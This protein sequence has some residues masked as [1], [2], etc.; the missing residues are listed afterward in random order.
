[1]L[2]YNFIPGTYLEDP[3]PIKSQVTFNPEAEANNI[4]S[5]LR[6]MRGTASTLGIMPDPEFGAYQS[7]ELPEVNDRSEFTKGLLRGVDST[8][9]LL[10]GGIGAVGDVLGMDS[11]RDWGYENYARNMEEAEENKA[12]IGS[13]SEVNSL[14][15]FGQ[16]TMGVLGELAPTAAGALASGGI[17]AL[18]GKYYGSKLIRK[19]VADQIENQVQKGIAD[20]A[21]KGIA[22]EAVEST[23]RKQAQQQ[24]MGNLMRKG[25]TAAVGAYTS[26]TEGGG[27]W[28]Q[29]VAAHGIE[30]ASPGQDLLFG[31][32][33]GAIETILGAEISLFKSLTGKTVSD[34]VEQSFRK[35]LVKGFA[36]A[37]LS[38]GGQEAIQETLSSINANILDSKGLIT[39]EDIEGIFNAAVAGAI[40]GVAFHLPTSW[41]DARNRKKKTAAQAEID[42]I[43]KKIEEAKAQKAEQERLQTIE[44]E[45]IAK[46]Q[47]YQDVVNDPRT[48]FELQL[49]KEMDDLNAYWDQEGKDLYSAYERHRRALENPSQ[50]SP[51]AIKAAQAFMKKFVPFQEAR[52]ASII[53]LSREQE[54]KRSQFYSNRK[55]PN[56]EVEQIERPDWDVTQTYPYQAA[57]EMQ[58]Q[59][60]RLD[61]LA[62][63]FEQGAEEHN[64][65]AM[66]EEE[67]WRASRSATRAM[68]PARQ[69]FEQKLLNEQN[70][71]NS[72]WDERGKKIYSAYSAAKAVLERPNEFSAA[73][74]K[75]A[76]TALNEYK[77]FEQERSTAQTILSNRQQQERT[78]FYSGRTREN[79]TP[80]V[81][82]L[83]LDWDPSLSYTETFNFERAEEERKLNELGSMFEE[84]ARIHDLIA[85][86]DRAE[87]NRQ[88]EGFSQYTPGLVAREQEILNRT[89]ISD[90]QKE[91]LLRN[92]RSGRAYPDRT[93]APEDTRPTFG[94]IQYLRDK[95]EA[96]KLMPLLKAREA[97][98]IQ[99]QLWK[100]YADREEAAFKE[101]WD[102]KEASLLAQLQKFNQIATQ[103]RLTADQEYDRAQLYA[104]HA[105]FL[106]DKKKA[107][108]ALDAKIKAGYHSADGVFLSE[109]RIAA[110][111]VYQQE[112]IDRALGS[113][114]YDAISDALTEA[115]TYF[116][117]ATEAINQRI[118]D[119][120]TA[121]SEENAAL[122]QK[123]KDLT[124]T[125]DD[126][127]RHKTRIDNLTK[128]RGKALKS[129][130]KM[131]K[132]MGDISKKNAVLSSTDLNNLG[133]AIQELY[134]EGETILNLQR[135]EDIF[136]DKQQLMINEKKAK[137]GQLTDALKR[138]RKLVENNIDQES[139]ARVSQIF[140]NV[141]NALTNS[142]FERDYPLQN[143]EAKTTPPSVVAQREQQQEQSALEDA[144]IKEDFTNTFNQNLTSAIE[145]QQRA[146]EKEDQDAH[147]A[148]VQAATK[149]K[150]SSVPREQLARW[151]KEDAARW[152][153][154]TLLDPS[155]ANRPVL[156]EMARDTARVKAAERKAQEVLASAQAAMNMTLKEQENPATLASR[157]LGQNRKS[158]KEKKVHSV[159]TFLKNTLKS[160]PGLRDNTVICYDENDASI[161][162]ELK[163]MLANVNLGLTKGIKYLFTGDI[164]AYNIR[165][166]DEANSR[167]DNLAIAEEMER[168]GDDPRRIKLATGWERHRKDGKWRYELDDSIYRTIESFDLGDTTKT[169]TLSDILLGA[170]DLFNSYPV[171]M[172][173]TVE[174]KSLS[175]SERGSYNP[176]TNT[177][178]INSN[179]SSADKRL[180]LLHE[181]QHSIQEIE[182][183]TRGTST[184]AVISKRTLD[185]LRNKVQVKRAEKI[186]DEFSSIDSS[187]SIALEFLPMR[188]RM[189]LKHV[190]DPS[191]RALFKNNLSK[192]T[193]YSYLVKRLDAFI[194]ELQS[195]TVTDTDAEFQ[196]ERVIY[197]T[198]RILESIRELESKTKRAK[199][200][201]RLLS[202]VNRRV[203]PSLYKDAYEVY[204]ENAGEVEAR[205]VAHR[206]NMTYEERLNSLIEDTQ[207]VSYEDQQMLYR[208]MGGQVKGVYYKGKLYLFAKNLDSKE[209]AI[210]TLIHE[211]VAHYGLRSIMNDE[212]L[213]QFLNLVFNSFAGTESWK[214]FA[215]ARPEYFKTNDRLTQAEEYVAYIAEQM[216]VSELINPENQSIFNRIVMFLRNILSKLGLKTTLTHKDI[217]DVLKLSAYNLQ[218]KGGQKDLINELN[219]IDMYQAD[220]Q[221]KEMTLSEEP[222][223]GVKFD[224]VQN[225]RSYFA[226]ADSARTGI[227]YTRFA[228]N[229]PNL[230]NT[231]N[232]ND[233]LDEQHDKIKTR[234]AK[235]ARDF[236]AAPAIDAVDNETFYVSMFN[237][238][239]G[240]YPSEQDARTFIDNDAMLSSITG[241]D[242]YNFLASTMDSK[243][244]ATEIMNAYGIRGAQ[245]LNMGKN[246]YYLF[247]GNNINMVPYQYNLN[248]LSEPK[249]LVTNPKDMV[250]DP[251]T[252]EPT[253]KDTPDQWTYMNE[254][255][256]QVA[257][258]SSWLR[259]VADVIKTGTSRADDGTLIEHNGW[260]RFIEGTV[261]RYRRL[262]VVQDYLKK[263]FKGAV[264]FSTNVY[265]NLQGLTNRI[266]RRQV[267]ADNK[268]LKPIEDV[269][270]EVT[271]DLPIYKDGKLIGYKKSTDSDYQDFMLRLFDGFLHARH[272]QERNK[273]VSE[274]FR[275]RRWLDKDGNPH[276]KNMKSAEQGQD[277]INASGM[278]DAEAQHL[279]DTLGSISGFQEAAALV[280][281]MNRYTLE[282]MLEM[283]LI[284][285]ED[286]N[287]MAKYNYYVPL[288]GWED[289]VEHF[290]PG[291]YR[292]RGR[293]LSTGGKRPV[294][295][296]KGRDNKLPASP[297][298]RSWQQMD[299][300]I[301]LGMRNE[302][303]RGF[304][305]LVKN[306]SSETELWEVD[307]K[308]PEA[309]RLQ[310]TKNG[311]I[312]LVTKPSE[313]HGSG[314][315]AVS[316]IDE[317]GKPVRIVIK[318]K[319]LADAMRGENMAPTGA[320][321]DM[322]RKYTGM[323]SKLMTSRNPLFAMVNPIRDM[324]T[325]ALNLGSVIEENQ[326]RGLMEKNGIIQR[327]V[328]TDVFSK[329]KLN[330]LWDMASMDE[331]KS[332]F[333]A[334]KYDPRDVQDLMDWRKNGGHTKSISV[335]DMKD[336]SKALRAGIRKDGIKKHYD[337]AMS[338]LDMLSDMT[339]NVVRFSVYQNVQRAFEENIHRR[340]QAEGWSSAR[341][342]QEIEM[343][344]QKSAN[345]ALDCTVNFTKRGAWANV[346]NPLF[347]FS[348]ASIQGFARIANNLWRPTS[349]P[350]QNFKRVSKFMAM[351][352]CAPLMHGFI[353][354][355]IM[356][357]DE[358]GLNKYDKIPAYIKETNLIIPMPFGDGGYIKV[359]LPYGYNVFWSM[360][361]T[362]DTVMAGHQ[363]PAD[364]ALSIIK[365][366]LS[367]ITP[368][369]PSQGAVAF[370]PTIFKPL[371]ELAAN[372]N[373]AG[374]PI[375]PE[376]YSTDMLPEHMKS[377]ERTP[378]GY[379]DIAGLLNFITGGFMTKSN[380]GA[381]DISP[382]T[383]EHLAN[384]YLGGIYRIFSQAADLA[385]S[386]MMGY[387]VEA[388]NIP[389][390]NRLYGVTDD[391]N[392]RA[393]YNR[394]ADHVRSAQVLKKQLKGTEEE[395]DL[396]D[397][398]R[399][400]FSVEKQYTAVNTELNKVKQAKKDLAKRYPKRGEAYYNQLKLLEKREEKIMQKFNRVAHRAGLTME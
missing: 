244:K 198:E 278:S 274:R 30:S 136:R 29:D 347:A 313:L 51:R 312:I 400:V 154:I 226:D 111:N 203:S 52:N 291:R 225:A 314:D 333:D 126:W 156:E 9:A 326:M 108:E 363:H 389:L 235:L 271:A 266:S 139:K 185:K 239:F 328:V 324:M 64:A 15:S 250:L 354:R 93:T 129:L 91:I 351:G 343:A 306:T 76:L 17:G 280:D 37:A 251:E 68:T 379:K 285:Q 193:N 210:R 184:D 329:K 150:K 39:E 368:L 123:Q 316:Y 390:L 357:D 65:I 128:Q 115:S 207:D 366:A 166:I 208:A 270:K 214:K 135:S 263:K 36:K 85:T 104:K 197:R 335:Y 32:A 97:Q 223:Y 321:V 169:Y 6:A 95:E 186:Y 152:D 236:S 74:R 109:A 80:P 290:A 228:N 107:R 317:N 221:N 342:Q 18:A 192:N 117:K 279:I 155:E 23:L 188:I 339:E 132:L 28:G 1:M 20:A 388:K 38:E 151:A 27:N 89:D 259:K 160:L 231:L 247:E 222:I 96:E 77:K 31:V 180:T 175:T 319:W 275:G 48:Q 292:P 359:P 7:Y 246:T 147:E 340:A 102:K 373:F 187:I 110:N 260:E 372:K 16:Y 75:K 161:P 54:K 269:L 273:S 149:Q 70:E 98:R 26:L 353:C 165:L 346:F 341:V 211:G 264:D 369:D 232:L 338:Y 300:I 325:A 364:G 349:T 116:T 322:M 249:F 53:S 158:L 82:P 396:L 365:N 267:D 205:N 318:D 286:F 78:A 386:P 295:F 297:L 391:D 294:Q 22:S 315:S 212:Q 350:L 100:E 163:N 179:L 56:R 46:E 83:K 167:L 13:I 170:E 87:H 182:G 199:R 302:V 352:T 138:A 33:S 355:A 395:R 284:T 227:P 143:P 385:L 283:K 183:W 137:F 202:I 57:A 168:Q 218:K 92:L 101:E 310:V 393:I 19:A 383:I 191:I 88:M 348:S 301:A 276:H 2:S 21:A 25:G 305:Q 8:Q 49:Q 257:R 384:S 254:L 71:F 145:A 356:G 375:K 253:T 3:I 157:L 327:K 378:K 394:Y 387:Q 240:P 45:R 344:K 124:L 381:L 90:I 268:Y 398:R 281:K 112:E 282:T 73:E 86:A 217:R 153:A 140:N 10:Y 204:Y 172:D 209:D 12:A 380:I 159:I 66:A 195:K 336:R 5:S 164:G 105:K 248:T 131:N 299:D 206:A 242:V 367:N 35:E 63:M 55:R 262:K 245:Y 196:N 323:M 178:T 144:K 44:Q 397:A 99:H 213:G 121:L 41:S 334:S 60:E 308:N 79:R 370:V 293:S 14:G 360:G 119:I 272:A 243:R 361:T 233:S 399:N 337:E 392:T 252:G 59:E 141:E 307:R 358:D 24:V 173:I 362:L 176:A 181:I 122:A 171:L 4:I 234:I 220:Q 258:E 42:D 11:V 127:K 277:I 320:I 332:T 265:Q 345:I 189:W 40:G 118:A 190:E 216:K 377:W 194:S 174:Q 84:G 241:W 81:S 62:A 331:G 106:N 219:N 43:V 103:S 224:D 125:S 201:I 200:L 94:E 288:T 261:D 230:T 376:G 134:H 371:V 47:Q 296:A 120:N 289:M 330:M 61:S 237:R 229:E 146:K 374:A 148:S 162:I 287:N 72:R 298:L 133:L 113:G 311:D 255:F 58:R 304:G 177:I 142:N 67:A 69:A 382:E 130:R 238:V 34:A 309:V 215:A 114:A 303:M 256:N 50:S